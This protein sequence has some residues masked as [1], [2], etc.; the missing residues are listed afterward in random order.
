MVDRAVATFVLAAIS[1]AWAGYSRYLQYD[2]G[3]HEKALRVGVT[4]ALAVFVGLLAL[5]TAAL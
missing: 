5:A 4:T 1:A 2:P 3:H